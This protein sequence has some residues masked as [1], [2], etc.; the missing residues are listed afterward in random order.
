MI[1]STCEPPRK[2]IVLGNYCPHNFYGMLPV[3][4]VILSMC[5]S[6][7]S[8]VAK[9]SNTTFKLEIWAIFVTNFDGKVFEAPNLKL[10]F[11]PLSIT[12]I[13]LCS[14]STASYLKYVHKYIPL[15]LVDTAFQS[16]SILAL[17][18]LEHLKS[19]IFTYPNRYY[20]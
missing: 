10:F 13:V 17:E 7:F 4:S 5:T 8:T 12:G 18:R 11:H 20:L 6:I 14:S 19:W 1:I 3:L 15:T 2:H 9:M 16:R